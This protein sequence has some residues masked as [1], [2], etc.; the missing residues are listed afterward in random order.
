M[1]LRG[2]AHGQQTGPFEVHLPALKYA[3]QEVQDSRVGDEDPAGIIRRERGRPA[4]G[5]RGVPLR[6]K[7]LIARAVGA[8]YDV[9]PVVYLRPHR[10]IY[11]LC[12]GQGASGDR[13][14]TRLNFQSPLNIVCR[15][16][17]EKKKR[18]PQ[19]DNQAKLTAVGKT[20]TT[21]NT[22]N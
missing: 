6:E 11:G 12:E 9:H 18:I 4:H 21:T 16:L 3:V 5:D 1:E 2:S 20:R 19:H 10:L 17:L 14:S 13:K 8:P 7:P 15:L 22:Q